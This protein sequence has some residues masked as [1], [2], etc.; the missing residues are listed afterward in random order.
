MGAASA[1]AILNGCPYQRKAERVSTT[2]IPQA[3]DD[4]L[5]DGIMAKPRETVGGGS[6]QTPGVVACAPTGQAPVC[7]RSASAWMVS[8]AFP[9]ARLL[10]RT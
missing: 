7:N 8:G 5:E 10:T 2:I 6:S 4:K 1:T 3:M 9:S